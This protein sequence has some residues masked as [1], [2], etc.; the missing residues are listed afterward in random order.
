MHRKKKVSKVLSI[1][2]MLAA[3]SVTVL[4]GCGKEKETIK[5]ETAA[6]APSPEVIQRP[7]AEQDYGTDDKVVIPK[8]V[9]ETLK[10]VNWINMDEYSNG[11]LMM[12]TTLQGNV[13]RENPSMYVIHDEIIE[14]PEGFNGSQFWFE[15]L[16]TL[17]TGSEA[18]TKVEFTDPYEM[19]LE[20]KDQIQ[21]AVIYHER[22]TDEAMASREN[23][24]SRYGD[25][26]VLNLTLMMCGQYDAVALNYVQYNILKEEYGLE[27]EI[28]GDTTK[29]MEKEEDGSFSQERGS[30]EVWTQVYKYALDTFGETASHEAL[31]HNAGFQ[32]AAFDYYVAHKMFVYNRIFSAEATEEERNLELSMLNVS[33][34]N[35][36]MFGCWYLQADEGSFVPL[37]TE[38]YKFYVVSY[39]SFNVSWTSGLPYEELGVE[40]EKLTLDPTKKYVTFTFTEGDNNSYLQYRMP[41][42]FQSPSKG[43]Y[44]IGWTIAPACWDMNPNIIR[45]YRENWSKGDGLA[46]PEA[47]VDYVYHTP[48]VESQDEFFAISDAYFGRVGSGFMRT[49]QPDVVN[50][51]PYAEKMQNL[52]AIVC[53]YLETG[54]SNYNNDLSHFLFR[55]VPVFL[56]FNGREVHSLIQADGGS[57]CFYAISLYG[58]SQ[59]PSTVE[60]VMDSLGDDYV[61]VTP[62]QMAD[63]Y[64][65][66]Y[67]PEFTDVTE[68][69]FQSGMTRSE[70]GFLYKA[71]AYTD[72]DA[73]G[74]SR[75]ADGENYFIYKFDLADGV[76]EAKFHVNIKGNYQIEASTDYLNWTV[77]AKGKASEKTMVAFDASAVAKG[78]QALYLRFGDQTPENGDGVDLYSLYLTTDLAGASA[79]DISSSEDD[80]YLVAGGEKVEGGRRG[81]FTYLLSLCEDV[82]SGDLM[83]AAQEVTVQI[84]EDNENYK[85]LPMHKVGNT[86]YAQ[87]KGLS[88]KVYLK[89]NSDG[90]VSKVRFRKT[91]DA[92]TQLS[93]SPVSNPDTA[94]YLLSLDEQE[95][96]EASVSS[97][98]EVDGNNAMVYRFV[99]DD[100]VKE[101]KLMLNT[102]GTYALSVSNDG[103]HYTEIYRT[104]EGEIAPSPNA[105]DITNYAAGG[106]TVYVKMEKAVES[107]NKPARMLKL[108][109]LTDLTSDSLLYKL[110]K[111]RD[112][113]AMVRAGTEAELLLLDESQSVNHFLYEESARCLNPQ[114]NAAFVYKLDTN[115][116]D[117]FHALGIEKTEVTKLRITMLIA[118]AYKVSVSGDGQTWTEVAD[119]NDVGVQSASN[120]KDLD[121]ALTDAMKDG[122]VYVKVS[123]SSAYEVGKTHDGLMWNMQFYLN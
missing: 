107:S 71:S 16:D 33:K 48:P 7:M 58:W 84:S 55:D 72:Y 60:A 62:K 29:F 73:M 14:G 57:P 4:S 113:D 119:S 49:L 39:E 64:R 15:Q 114:E 86:W 63:L 61:A 92:V 97:S 30:R 112:P 50:P 98:R 20:Y 51:L 2:F 83:V 34:P 36:P 17:Y 9:G 122:V 105:L 85:D 101:A 8:P 38:N 80:A 91:P 102:S 95:V 88:K 104:R 106:Q 79:Y 123:R 1:M 90:P 111:E 103:E 45:Y 65:Q 115:S 40:E 78:G 6:E 46:I 93:F 21:G 82:V 22:L 117:F 109:L 75:M 94:K 74:G 99:T 121:V 67:G 26:A 42:M 120:Q 23:Y 89:L 47:G 70:M 11:D 100:K 27:L 59:D 116:D 10:T 31:G 35:T 108:R 118:N 19:I 3:L 77:M 13:N 56:N 54:N 96:K 53:G 110:D 18:F 32:A 69:S 28:L 41:T 37:L 66:Y 87:L 43:K 81:E 12:M 68:A 76:K 25:M 5:E 24:Q 52:E 44:S